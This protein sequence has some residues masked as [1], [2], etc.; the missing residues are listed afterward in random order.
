[1]LKEVYSDSFSAMGTRFGIVIPGCSYN[2]SETIPPLIKDEVD[3]LEYII[4]RFNDESALSRIN[5]F[6]EKYPS[7]TDDELW[8][9]I[10]E[11]RAFNKN[12]FGAFDISI[13]ALNELW[14]NSNEPDPQKL[15]L[16]INNTG[17]NN[18]VFDEQKLSIFFKNSDIEFDLGSVGKGIALRSTERILRQNGIEHAFVSFGESSILAIGSHPNGDG[19]KIGVPHTFEDNNV[20]AVTLKDC[21]VSVSGNTINNRI[22]G[23]VNV[24]NPIT[25]YPI[26]EYKS[27]IVIDK[28][29]VTAEALST[30]FMVLN[31]EQ[32]NSVLKL[33]PGARAVKIVYDKDNSPSITEYKENSLS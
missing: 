27:V 1:M 32:I 17:F 23:R 28:C 29:P 8:G 26:N 10:N 16:L 21:S 2:Q 5:R 20:Y 18:V 22:S 13:R 14:N 25:G 19:W 6:A 11:C 3:R 24:I 12:T 31:D 30:A 7:E 4:S 9:I 15:K 33:Y